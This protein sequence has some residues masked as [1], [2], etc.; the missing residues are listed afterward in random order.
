MADILFSCDLDMAYGHFD[1]NV[2]Q[3]LKVKAYF[4][5][6][7]KGIFKQARDNWSNCH[8]KSHLS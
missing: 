2:L 3:V 8:N 7:D 4:C 6:A 5:N 1:N